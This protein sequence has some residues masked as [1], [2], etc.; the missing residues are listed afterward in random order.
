MKFVKGRENNVA[1]NVIK[2]G[3]Q[4]DLNLLEEE[5]EEWV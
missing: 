1:P 5:G 3:Q 4:F 2:Y